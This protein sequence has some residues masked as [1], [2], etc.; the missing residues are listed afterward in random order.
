MVRA[1]FSRALRASLSCHLV[2]TCNS[3]AAYMFLNYSW[4]SRSA[5]SVFLNSES[6]SLDPWDGLEERDEEPMEEEK[7]MWESRSCCGARR[8]T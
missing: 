4:W 3:L 1:P 2:T 7:G 5:F 8:V 6:W